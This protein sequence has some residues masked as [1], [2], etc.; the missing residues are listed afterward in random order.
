M[1]QAPSLRRQLVIGRDHM[2]LYILDKDLPPVWSQEERFKDIAA[3]YVEADTQDCNNK[4]KKGHSE[5][6]CG[7][8]F[9][10]WHRRLGH[11]SGGKMKLVSDI[12]SLLNKNRDFI[13]DVS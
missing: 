11:M 4:S 2:G 13:C 3:G 12:T 8:I 7:V 5:F 9:D 1:L 6:V 10:I